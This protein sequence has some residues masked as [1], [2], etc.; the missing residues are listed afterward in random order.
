MKKKRKG[1]GKRETVWF[2]LRCCSAR[3]ARWRTGQ[4][5]GLLLTPNTR[6]HAHTQGRAATEDKHTRDKWPLAFLWLLLPSSYSLH[7]LQHFSRR[8][9][10]HC[11]RGYRATREQSA[12]DSVAMAEEKGQKEQRET[13]GKAAPQQELS[14][15]LLF[16][17]FGRT[18]TRMESMVFLARAMSVVLARLASMEREAGCGGDEGERERK[19]EALQGGRT[20]K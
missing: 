10:S 6:T 8:N 2:L 15:S 9:V 19:K 7:P 5:C 18:R 11:S 20:G 13:K 14:L 3:V 17:W 12:G 1:K 16:P 4:S